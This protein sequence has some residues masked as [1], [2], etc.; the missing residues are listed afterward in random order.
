MINKLKNFLG[1]FMEQKHVVEPEKIISFSELLDDCI[2][3]LESPG[4]TKACM[5]SEKPGIIQVYPLNGNRNIFWM[6]KSANSEEYTLTFFAGREYSS[7]KLGEHKKMKKLYD[8]CKQ[9]EQE[10]KKIF[11]KLAFAELQKDLTISS[12][13]IRQYM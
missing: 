2:K 8:L 7:Y 12:K 9:K 11:E 5:C 6:A 1:K 13:T 3:L 4:K 10:T